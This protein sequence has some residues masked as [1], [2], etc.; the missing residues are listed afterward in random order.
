MADN[1]DG[2]KQI[3]EKFDNFPYF[4]SITYIFADATNM[5]D[6]FDKYMTKWKILFLQFIVHS[7]DVKHHGYVLLPLL[8]ALLL[9]YY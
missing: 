6:N 3:E 9:N 1:E 5:N 2:S 8:S 7:M 4:H